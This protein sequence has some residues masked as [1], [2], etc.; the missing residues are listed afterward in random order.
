MAAAPATTFDDIRKSLRS[1]HFLPVYLLHGAE[2]YYIDELVKDFDSILS[3]DEKVFNQ[4]VLYAPDTEPAQVLDVCRRI[5]M[6][7]DRQVVI[8]KE[9]QSARADRLSKLVPYLS[10]PAD[11]TI[12]VICYRGADA[13]ADIVKAVQKGGGVVF[14][15]KKVADWNLPAVI[16]EHIRAKGLSA[17]QKALEMLRD[18]IGSDLS[19]LYNEID[20]LAALLPP[21]AAITP[22]VI[23]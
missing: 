9:A 2:G 12:L 10:A 5:P 4:Y 20:K 17:D 23:E 21:R 18:Y 19:R 15:S 8:L 6:M 22:E 7:S 13:K 11:G 16:G 1:K 3:E 14:N